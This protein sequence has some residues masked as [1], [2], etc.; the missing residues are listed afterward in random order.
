MAPVLINFQNLYAF[1][2]KR[3]Y[4]GIAVPH[5][6]YFQNI[7]HHAVMYIP[8]RCCTF[9]PSQMKEAGNAY[10]RSRLPFSIAD[11]K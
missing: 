7:Q 3:D 9:I 4:T 5:E 11:S 6:Q 2:A 8:N 10:E 1:S